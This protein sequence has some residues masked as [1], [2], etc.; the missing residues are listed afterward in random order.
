MRM[1]LRNEKRAG[2]GTWA[3]VM[4][5]LSFLVAEVTAL[6][7]VKFSTDQKFLIA[8]SGHVNFCCA[9]G[10]INREVYG[11]GLLELR[12]D[13]RGCLERNVLVSVS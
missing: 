9:A 4:F 10:P 3:D 5:L 8:G 12:V 11:D 13:I 6:D 1:Y 7:D 2:V